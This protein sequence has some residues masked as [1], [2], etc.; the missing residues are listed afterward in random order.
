MSALNLMKPVKR[1]KREFHTFNL[2]V[3]FILFATNSTFAQEKKSFIPRT[4]DWGYR[5]VQ[6]D[7][8]HPYKKYI[9][10][11][12][13]IA[14]RPETKWIF[15]LSLAHIFRTKNNDGITRPST[16]RVNVS[17]SQMKQFSV[18]PYFEYFS[19]ANKL[20]IR[21]QYQYTNF[22]EY[23][24]GIGPDAPESNKEFYEFKMQRGY[25][26]A[27]Y[28]LL[29]GFYAGLQYGY[30]KMYHLS[31]ESTGFLQN[32][33]TPGATGYLASGIGF[34]CYSDTRDN[35]Y[36]PFKG[37]FIEFSG[38]I[39]H[40]AFGSEY[41]FTNIT[42]DARKFVQLWNENI[43][44]F[45][46]F[47][48]SNDGS[49][50]FR[51]MGTIGSESYMRGYYNGRF[52][53]YN[54][55]SFQTEFRKTIWGPVGAAFFLGMGTVNPSITNVFNQLKPNYGLGLRI[56]AIPRERINVR[57]DYGFGSKG[58]SALYLTLNEAF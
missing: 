9:F 56:K 41:N 23:Y 34:T 14:Y 36:F 33:T 8:A 5:I 44:A 49:T 29:P 13:I 35:V 27:A 40:S 17:Y 38:L 20:N 52:R 25:V 53:D 43:L 15:G 18:K 1:L 10:A 57:I 19:A 24:W 7:S 48:H 31:Y 54:A 50:P 30:E 3:M 28:M 37:N 58:I 4:I 12:P 22:G 26:K 2:C 45:Q 11:V 16:I 39:N 51:M 42:L 47:L 6:G 46:L 55:V 21:A 32:S